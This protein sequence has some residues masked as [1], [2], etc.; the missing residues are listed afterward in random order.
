MVPENDSRAFEV[1]EV[2]GSFDFE[3]NSGERSCHEVEESS[4]DE[5]GVQTLKESTE[6]ESNISFALLIEENDGQKSARGQGRE[7]KGGGEER[8]ER[9]C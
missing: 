6:R 3:M 8:K 7:G 9:V 2:L 1:L 5:I 4:D